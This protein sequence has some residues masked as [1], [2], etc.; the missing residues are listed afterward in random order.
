MRE[1]DSEYIR[2]RL[3]EERAR[4]VL[5]AVESAASSSVL[6]VVIVVVVTCLLWVV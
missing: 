4:S 6:L 3:A 1:Q 5:R 2:E